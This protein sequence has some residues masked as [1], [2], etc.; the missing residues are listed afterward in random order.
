MSQLRMN[1]I[2]AH[3]R[4]M[5]IAGLIRRLVRSLTPQLLAGVPK[6]PYLASHYKTG[7]ITHQLEPTGAVGAGRLHQ[8]QTLLEVG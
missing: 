7:N 8:V 4:D 3:V 6:D 5:Q 2:K 1:C